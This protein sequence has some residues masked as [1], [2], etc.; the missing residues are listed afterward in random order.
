MTISYMHTSHPETIF[1]YKQVAYCEYAV[2]LMGLT[3]CIHIT[4]DRIDENVSLW[5]RFI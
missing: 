3:W 5:I 4:V 1:S 2:Q